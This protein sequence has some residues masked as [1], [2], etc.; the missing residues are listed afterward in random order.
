MK[1]KK[2]LLP[3]TT[4]ETLA[5]VRKFAPRYDDMHPSEQA[6]YLQACTDW[7]DAIIE[8]VVEE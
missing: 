1:F 4:A 2:V 6:M 7:C 3:L 5:T 8:T